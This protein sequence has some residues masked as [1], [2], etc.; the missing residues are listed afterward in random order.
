MGW[1]I[2]YD[3]DF[4][5]ADTSP[6]GPGT[7]TG[8]GGAGK[9]TDTAG[10]RFS[11]SGNRLLGTVIGGYGTDHLIDLA[12]T[13]T[14]DQRVVFTHAGGEV[15]GAG[16]MGVLRYA[17]DSHFMICFTLGNTFYIDA[18]NGGAIALVGVPMSGYDVS[19]DHQYDFQ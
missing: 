4:N 16:P 5:R 8:A 17:D 2:L 9:L 3:D 14:N 7:T 1:Q 11:I 10:N 19:H 18:M 6:G 15:A 12:D 13:P